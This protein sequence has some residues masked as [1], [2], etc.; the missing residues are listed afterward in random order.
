MYIYIYIKKISHTKFIKLVNSID[1]CT[2][3]L[4]PGKLRLEGQ[5]D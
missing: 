3:K 4:L 1:F 2:Q 5:F